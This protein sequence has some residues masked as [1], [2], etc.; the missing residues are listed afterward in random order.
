MHALVSSVQ[1]LTVIITTDKV[2][3][4]VKL[5]ETRENYLKRGGTSGVQTSRSENLKC[6]EKSD[7]FLKPCECNTLHRR[8][9][10]IF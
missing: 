2:A 5:N 10:I 3:P 8:L 7:L 4:A 6:F 1:V 9:Y